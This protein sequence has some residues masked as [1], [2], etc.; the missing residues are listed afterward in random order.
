MI[1]NVLFD[2][3]QTRID[4]YL[5]SNENE[6]YDIPETV[7]TLSGYSFAHNNYIKSITIPETVTSIE[8]YAFVHSPNLQTIT[9]KGLQEPET[10]YTNVFTKTNSSLVINVPSN[11]KGTTFCGKT[12]TK[13]ST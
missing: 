1:D 5:A 6:H 13:S 4:V 2:I 10:C 3:N 8:T 7:K 11:Y 12:V 9:F